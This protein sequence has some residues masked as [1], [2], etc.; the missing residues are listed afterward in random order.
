MLEKALRKWGVSYSKAQKQG[1]LQRAASKL[2]C[3]G[4]VDL[5]RQVGYGKITPSQVVEV[6]VPENKRKPST[7]EPE[8]AKPN[9][10]REII[11][12]VTRRRS[13][14]GIM[15]A[16]EAD[17]LV[18]YARCCSPL[19]GDVIV[20][21]IT[22]GRGVTVHRRDCP[23]ALDLDPDRRIDVQW[24]NKA[25]GEHEVAIQVLSADKPGLLALISQSF[26]DAGVNISQAHC[27][28]TDDGRA[29]NT[30]HARV[31]DLDQLKSV[32]RSLTRIKGVF[33]VDRV[34]ERLG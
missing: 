30:F 5:I 22:R 21:F 10:I 3:H 23:K 20:G 13:S 33:S 24:D 4:V 28:T 2:K 18:R 26:S 14:S 19:P 6:I 16:G 17:V 8:E 31:T 29:V 25:H 9:P 12:K 15:V 1:D 34:A 27:R 11:R 7:E 32:I